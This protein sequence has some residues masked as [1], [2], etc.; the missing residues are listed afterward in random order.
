MTIFMK[1][2]NPKRFVRRIY[3]ILSNPENKGNI[4]W[5]ECGQS[6]EILNLHG[7]IKEILPNYFKHKK[8]SS[9]IRQ[10]NFYNFKKK[11]NTGDGLIYSHPDFIRG[12]H[13]RIVKVV[14]KSAEK[15]NNQHNSF[16]ILTAESERLL[17][18]YETLQT[19]VNRINTFNLE[20]IEKIAYAT[21]SIQSLELV[22]YHLF[23]ELIQNS[24]V[25]SLAQ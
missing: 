17:L 13:D 15:K 8:A 2:L 6:F 20:L 18:K 12:E 22:N 10:L 5:T 16:D 9:F 24:I 11:R 7:L 19:E 3:E 25:L 14:R 4:A 21:E 23:N 1:S